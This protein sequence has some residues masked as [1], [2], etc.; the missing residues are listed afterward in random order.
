[1]RDRI[2]PALFV[3]VA[4]VIVVVSVLVARPA[5]ATEAPAKVTRSYFAEK[6]GANPTGRI[7]SQVVAQTGADVAVAMSCSY[8]PAESRIAEL[9]EGAGQ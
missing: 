4:G 5:G 1:M 6:D 7:C 9:L 8:P 2:V 3:L